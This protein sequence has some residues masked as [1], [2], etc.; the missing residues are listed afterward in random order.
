MAKSV[1][2]SSLLLIFVAIGLQGCGGGGVGAAGV[3][4]L[5]P[6]PSPPPPPPPDPSGPHG[7]VHGAPFAVQGI[8][9]NDAGELDT[10]AVI[11]FRYVEAV[12][13]YEIRLPG[14]ATGQLNLL[15]VNGSYDSNGWSHVSSSRHRVTNAPY[16][17]YVTLDRPVGPLSPDVR[18]TYTSF[19]S[20]EGFRPD[21]S[22]DFGHF[23]Y[24]IPTAAGDVPLTGTA[25]YTAEVRGVSSLFVSGPFQDILAYVSGDARL[26]F[27]FAAG[28]LAGH[29]NAML[30]PWDCD[31]SLGRYE[32][33]ETVFSKGSQT[34]SGKLEAPGIAGESGFLGNFTGPQAAELLARFHAPFKH[35][36]S[37][38]TGTIFGVW[39]GKKD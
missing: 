30:C 21:E 13:R 2:Q 17:I 15:G 34:F 25:S 10:D 32:F 4:P 11:E 8:V 18:L 1:C 36:V 22:M 29:M 9:F 23:A 7:L 28:T 33:T 31:V 20:W 3:A 6:P 39:A 38:E 19:G 14:A 27:D 35:P 16:D 5:P 37:G 26:Q 12:D 24:G